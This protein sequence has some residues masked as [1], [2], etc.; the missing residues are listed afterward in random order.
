M[1]EYHIGEPILFE[2]GNGEVTVGEFLTVLKTNYGTRYQVRTVAEETA[3]G[4][5][6]HLVSEEQILEPSFKNHA[7]IQDEWTTTHIAE[8]NEA[9]GEDVTHCGLIV[10]YDSLEKAE[11]DFGEFALDKNI[12][13]PVLD[14]WVFLA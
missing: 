5:E 13:R 14:K 9:F 6:Y 12:C 1:K 7:P 4:W 8:I 3:D 2:I 10:I 11:D